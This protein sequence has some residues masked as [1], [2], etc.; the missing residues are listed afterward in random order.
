M[1]EGEHRTCLVVINKNLAKYYPRK[2]VMGLL[3]AEVL[4]HTSFRL[5]TSKSKNFYL[6]FFYLQIETYRR[7]FQAILELYHVFIVM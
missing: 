2:L 5:L 7:K 3:L 4:G 6:V 1:K